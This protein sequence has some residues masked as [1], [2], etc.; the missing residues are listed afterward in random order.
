MNKL[1]NIDDAL[2]MMEAK[3]KNRFSHVY[4]T[5]VKAKELAAAYNLD[6]Y[7]CAI[8]AILHD[9][10]KYD[11]IESLKN[12]LKE[13]NPE[14]LRYNEIIYHGYAGS[15]LIQK[16]LGIEDSEIINAVKYHVTGHPDMDD[17]AKVI[18]IA[19][20]TEK[21]RTQPHV[22]FCRALSKMSLDLGVLAISDESLRY[23]RKFHGND[24]H[25]LTEQTYQKFLEKVGT[26]AYDAIRNDYKSM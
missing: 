26:L 23:L 22:D 9:Y 17:I 4:G 14:M 3:N 5:Y 20:Y 24:I 15:Y 21:N 1:I 19:D 16:E 10:A 2:K 12:I 25:P 6:L 13:I 18:Y 7:K 8:A 11:N